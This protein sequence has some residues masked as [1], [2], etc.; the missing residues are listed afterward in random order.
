MT[1]TRWIALLR[2]INVGGN[3]QIKMADLR[4]LIA[5]LGFDNVKT[6]LASGN[7]AFDAVHDDPAAIREAVEQGTAAVFGF[8]VSV[9]V[10]PRAQ[11]VDLVARDP[12]AGIPVT[13]ET[14][15]Y[16]TFLPAPVVTQ[17]TI[18]YHAPAQ[19][20]TIISATDGEVCSVLT[21]SPTSR[22]VDSM[23]M[24][25]R[26]FGAN[27]TTRNWNTVVKLASL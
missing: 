23:S 12:F 27:I 17:L 7:V 15:L 6:A 8:V 24:L 2:G 4:A 14:R 5:G 13:A 25:E 1:P 16:V 22:T 10:R 18:P 20:F 9:I 19:D 21:L 11:I 26:E 3:K